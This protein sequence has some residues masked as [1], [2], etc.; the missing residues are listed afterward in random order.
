METSD[1]RINEMNP[2]R[3]AQHEAGKLTKKER[4]ELRKLVQEKGIK[5]TPDDMLELIKKQVKHWAYLS[6]GPDSKK[7]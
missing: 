7:G 3:Q 1:G 4:K 6:Y 5:I 2:L